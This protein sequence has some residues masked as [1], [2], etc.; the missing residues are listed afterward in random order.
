MHKHVGLLY[1]STESK[2]LL[3]ILNDQKW[4]IPTFS[5]EHNVI[6]DSK[7]IQTKYAEGKILPIELYT[8][9][10]NGF[11]YGTFVC[12]VDKEF[13]HVPVNTYCW[14]D[15]MDLPKNLH[16]GLKTTLTDNLVRTKLDTILELH[17]AVII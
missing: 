2:R 15:F 9:K 17:D 12:L 10:D 14:A 16:V 7:N 6:E 5:V 4:T 8:S 1:L 11:E 13:S 3:L